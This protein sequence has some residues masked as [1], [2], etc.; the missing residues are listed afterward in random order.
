MNKRIRIGVAGA[1]VFGGHHCRK[2][3]DIPQAELFGVFDVDHARAH[4]LAR[5][6]GGEVFSNFS[7]LVSNV[8]AVIIAAPAVAH[9]TLARQAL[10]S[11]LH[12]LVEKPIALDGAEAQT[13]IELATANGAVLQVGHQERYVAAAAGLLDRSRAPAKIDCIRHTAASGRCEDVSVVLDLMIHDI[14]LIRQLTN[15]DV[16]EV[17]ASGAEHAIEAELI[18]DNGSLVSLTASRRAAAPERRMTLVYGDGVIE[19]DFINRKAVNTT[20]SSLRPAFDGETSPLAYRDPLAF[21]AQDF[22]AAITE[23]RAPVVTGE[24]GR[25]ALLWALRI[26]QAAGLNAG[27]ALAPAAERLLA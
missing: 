5:Q 18:L 12:V 4:A 3:A 26:E 25:G 13:L 11:G 6:H 22:I 17:T 16:A 10:S 20:A 7:D 14:D 15:T 2:I 9:F 27:A 24:D 21:G 1:G 23:G 8:D 19:F